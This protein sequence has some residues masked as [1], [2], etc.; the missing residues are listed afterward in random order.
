MKIGDKEYK[1]KTKQEVVNY[2]KGLDLEL[3]EN[4]YYSLSFERIRDFLFNLP[5]GE[6][7]VMTLKNIGLEALTFTSEER[8]FDVELEDLLLIYI[9]HQ[10]IYKV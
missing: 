5:N 8:E 9:P 6:R 3:A 10:C 4:H 1:F 7:K 2:F